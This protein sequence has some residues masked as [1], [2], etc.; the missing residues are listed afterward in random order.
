[1]MWDAWLTMPE[2]RIAGLP[3]M[4]WLVFMYHSITNIIKKKD[5]EIEALKV[6]QKKKQE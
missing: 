1:M 3:L 6:K 2:T 4:A 5:E